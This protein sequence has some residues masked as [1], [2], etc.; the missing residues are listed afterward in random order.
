MQLSDPNKLFRTLN[1][2]AGNHSQITVE[3]DYPKA[4]GEEFGVT[5]LLRGM[6]R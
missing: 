6:N 2:E 3:I 4:H 5:Y 1:L